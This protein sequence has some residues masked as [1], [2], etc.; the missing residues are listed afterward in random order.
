MLKLF[1]VRYWP[2]LLP[3]VLYALW[4]VWRRR[5]GEVK[6]RTRGWMIAWA[7]SLLMLLALVAVGVLSLEGGQRGYAPVQLI[8]GELVDGEM[9]D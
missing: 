3:L 2:A 8:D 5:K 6:P 1:L 9:R 7:V 4:V